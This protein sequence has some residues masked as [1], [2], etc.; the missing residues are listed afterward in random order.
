M[1]QEVYEI[2][3]Q[4][5]VN[6]MDVDEFKDAVFTKKPVFY[7]E[8]NTL[9]MEIQTQAPIG[10][11]TYEQFVNKMIVHFKCKVD[12]QL[13]CH[14]QTMN[15]TALNQYIRFIANKQ[16]ELTVFAKTF[17]KIEGEKIVF[18]YESVEA[19]N[20]AKSKTQQMAHE[21][22]HYG[23]CLPL[24]VE[25]FTV[26]TEVEVVKVDY[27]PEQRQVVQESV[28][29]M[30]YQP[31]MKMENYP[32]TPIRD[33]M[34]G[35]EEV[36]IRG[37]IFLTE[38]KEIQNGKQIRSLYLVDKDACIKAQR[39]EKTAD[40]LPEDNFK[41][42]DTV[43]ISGKVQYSTWDKDVVF[44]A[45]GRGRSIVKVPKVRKQD[46]ASR[47]RVELHA[48]SK[49][50]EMDG[51]S[52]I[53]DYIKQANA[54]GHDAFAITDHNVVQGYPTA[55]RLVNGINSDREKKFKMIY[56]IEMSMI[57]DELNIVYNPTDV[58]I[59]NA[60]YC[61]FDLET[62]GLSSKYDHI[63]EFGAQIIEN[64]MPKETMQMFIKPPVPISAKITD[65][66]NISNQEVENAKSIE[67]AMDDI[68]D[69]IGDSILVAHNAGFDYGFMNEAL[70]RMGKEKLTNPVIDT[71]DLA[72]ALLTES[73][74]FALGNVA[75]HYKITYDA[76]VA[77]RADYDAQVLAEV[78]LRMLQQMKPQ[79]TLM[80]V[81]KLN[82][83][84]EIGS[85]RDKH[86]VVLAKN[87]QG[88]QDIYEL[89][90]S[91]HTEYLAAV[92]KSNNKPICQPR[93]PRKEIEKKKQAG[94]LY[95]GSACQNGE[96]FDAAMTKS[97]EI[98]KELMKFY[99]YIE[100]QPPANYMNLV[101]RGALNS[102][103]EVEMIVSN[104]IEL[105]RDMDKMVVATGDAHYV[106]EEKKE[107]RD[108][109]INAQGI[110]GVRH[111]L[112]IYKKEIRRSTSAP[113]QHFR[114]TQE[115]LD[116]FKFIGEQL[117]YEIVVENT[118]A[119]A[120]SIEYTYPVKKDLY[121]PSIE[122][123]DQILR[124][125]CYDTAHDIYGPDLPQIVK[126]RLEKEL[127]SI[128]GNGFEVVYYVSHLLV[129]HSLD[130]GYLVGSRGSVGSS[131]VAT[132]ANITEV[133][134]LA[135]HYICPKC[136]YSEFMDDPSINSGFDLPDKEC[137]HCKTH[138][139]GDG[140]NIPFETFLGFEGDKVPD[141][142]LNFSGEYQGKAHKFLQE[143]FGDAH[144]Y[145]AGTIATVASKTAFGY[146]KGYLE[147]M[148]KEGTMNNARI[149]YLAEQ[150]DGVRR[151]TGQHPG[152]II[153][154]PQDMS[155]N[156][157][158]PVQFPSNN[159][160]EDMKTTHLDYHDI[161][162]NV[163]KFDILG[164]V[165]P[166]AMKIL[167]ESSGVDV[168]KI[169]MND[170]D[171]M[172]IFSKPDT[173][174]IDTTQNTEKTGAA[175]IP[176]FGTKFVRGILEETKPKTFSELVTISGLSHGT[177]VWLNNAKNLVDDDKAKYRQELG[178]DHKLTLRDVIG[179]RDDIMVDLM[180]K[181][182]QP[183]TAFTIMESVRKGRGLRDEWIED[184]QANHVEAYYIDSCKK[185][186]YMFPKAHAVAYVMMAV[187]IAWFKV[188]KPLHYYGMFFSIRCD[189]YDIDAMTKGL[190]TIKARMSDIDQRRNNPETKNEVSAKEHNVYDAL[191]LAL[192]MYLRG[193]K[194][195]K[196][197][198][199]RSPATRF[200]VDETRD[201][202]LL[203]AFTSVDGLG[204]N[205]AISIVEARKEHPFIS[206]EDLLNRTQLSKTLVDKLDQLGAL[207]GLQDE[208]QMSL[209]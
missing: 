87:Q 49:L 40:V 162:A 78:F 140:Q 192:E 42:G 136:K 82:K 31:R 198:I 145:R 77:H 97:D 173:L 105:A 53:A 138:M 96:V 81:L 38:I 203:P 19:Q 197:D 15:A 26:D 181:G 122:N 154:F 201:D 101:N 161:E 163:L 135:P 52:A 86:I 152:G 175:G 10:L 3:L 14:K 126:D 117:A 47:K 11:Q 100:V 102:I 44:N 16:K 121:P 207:E 91:S 155:V 54:W 118:N 6:E 179:C 148:G 7:R 199:N 188:H 76:D 132:M 137:P 60:R 73:K 176:E 64:N 17:A 169:P 177:D 129:K 180:K 2:A 144:A 107:V 142:D 36:K 66:T 190:E 112:Y 46:H 41:E 20:E 202:S 35:M 157:F 171:T 156:E 79:K 143:Y 185:I 158:T 139:R 103:K 92:S 45:N 8:K 151:S 186:K 68:L 160:Y 1:N 69:F 62:T 111:P 204:T 83:V 90:S 114:T 99:D 89:V 193:F 168:R 65:L 5:G 34:D 165:D 128:I 147:E 80:D 146:V 63:I 125:I 119:I 4:I 67:E 149:T 94:N 23:I 108:I 13:S 209:F 167:E 18:S 109:F 124:D 21:L 70:V 189:A 29:P 28:K 123:C 9:A 85:I 115:M 194:I 27:D 39:F 71:L 113:D 37:E 59:H 75:R 133:N 170:P 55:Q 130:D 183:K 178:L 106:E 196:L 191:E 93:I 182:L 57:D 74:R 104:I 50:S 25:D 84:K 61:V 172:A 33:L 12:M 32:L 166:T 187:R 88:I 150:C 164:H 56:G 131:F 72:K 184:M 127:N 195:Q 95:I 159:P 98:V 200:V 43:E 153:V 205:V 116:C 48:H 22:E 208:N 174:M 51:V 120:D 110:G 58:D 24:V 206:K 134:P 30:S 141:I